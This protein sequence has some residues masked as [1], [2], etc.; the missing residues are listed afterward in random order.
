MDENINNLDEYYTY[1]NILQRMLDNISND[2]D[3]R[4]GS[5]IY[6]AI[7]PAATELA[8]MYF[9]LKNNM[10]L[11]FADTAVETY[12]DKICNQI[13]MQRR[14]AIKATRCGQFWKNEKKEDGGYVEYENLPLGSRFSI[15]NIVFKVIEKIEDNNVNN[16]YKLECETPGEIGNNCFGILIPIDNIE[17]LGNTDLNEI[18]IPGQEEETDDELRERYFRYVLE[19][20]FGGNI[21]DYKQK[22]EETDG[23]GLVYIETANDLN[24]YDDENVRVT[25]LDSNLSKASDELVKIVQNNIDPTQDGSGIGLAPIRT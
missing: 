19:V 20:P 6:N 21:A 12:L 17:G 18:I 22:I 2:I 9:T 24:E 23:V 4:E 14:E 7:A 1:E 16:A 15:D 25:F 8:Q 3:K 11:C 5:V 13:G 10:D